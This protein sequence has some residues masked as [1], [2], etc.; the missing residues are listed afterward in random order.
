MGA[1]DVR[2]MA[3]EL[4]HKVR[5]KV[6]ALNGIDPILMGF[7]LIS[8]RPQLDSDPPKLEIM[9]RR[10]SQR[11]DQDA[12]ALRQFKKDWHR[13]QNAFLKAVDYLHRRFP[14]HDE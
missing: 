12:G 9:A 3:Q 14:V 6:F 11:I 2:A 10:W 8:E 1:L 13:Y 7:N 4:R 5:D